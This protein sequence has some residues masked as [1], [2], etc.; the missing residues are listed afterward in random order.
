MEEDIKYNRQ[1]FKLKYCNTCKFVWEQLYCVNKR[2]TKVN[3]Y[4]DF[5]SYGLTRTECKQCEG[6]NNGI[7]TLKQK[8]KRLDT[9]Y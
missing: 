8:D 7:T 5:P 3:K 1:H 2:M 9:R 4:K 6:K